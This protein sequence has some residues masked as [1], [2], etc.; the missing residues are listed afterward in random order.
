[1]YS[2]AFT[3]DQFHKKCS[4]M[5]CKRFADATFKIIT[6][7]T[8]GQWVNIHQNATYMSNVYGA[9]Y[10]NNTNITVNTFV[11]F[12]DNAADTNMFL[13]DIV[14]FEHYNIAIS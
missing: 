4:W 6:T 8:R 14:I 9:F 1:M 5:F 11:P 3:W 10:T 2:V 7:F 12:F 13:W